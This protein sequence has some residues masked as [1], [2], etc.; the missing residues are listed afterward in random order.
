[1][2]K[3]FCALDVSRLAPPTG[4]GSLNTTGLLGVVDGVPF[5]ADELVPGPTLFTALKITEYVV[6]FVSP[7]ITNGELV[8]TDVNDVPLLIEY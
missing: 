8:P 3:V 4:I 6:P 7:V 5:T 1:M 2:Y